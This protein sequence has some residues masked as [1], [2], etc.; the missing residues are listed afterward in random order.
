MRLLLAT[1]LSLSACGI[2]AGE[3]GCDLRVEDAANGY[4]DRCQERTGLQGNALYGEFCEGLGGLQVDGGCPDEGKVLGCDITSAGSVG[5][6]IDWYYDPVTR[7]QA[8]AEC[9]QDDADLVEP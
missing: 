2:V 8:E 1:C 9:E 6:V 4:E 7:E 5:K 3:V